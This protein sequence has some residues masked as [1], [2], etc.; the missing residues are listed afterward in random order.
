VAE[1][2][3]SARWQSGL[4][5]VV[6]ARTFEL[7]VDE[8]SSDGGTDTGPMPTEYLLASLASCYAV[9]LAWAARKRS[10][11]LEPFTAEARG[12]YAGPAFG[13]FTVVVRFDHAPPEQI[14]T[15]LESAKRS[16]YVSNTLRRSSEIEV[17][18]AED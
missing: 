6:Q 9:S 10:L 12:T 17:V 3:V 11:D 1:R 4:R 2:S 7:V 8:Q 5:A 15:L 16:C 13:H 18:L 14:D